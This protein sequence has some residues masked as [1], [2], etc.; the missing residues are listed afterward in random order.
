ML[1]TPLS[2]AQFKGEVLG[3]RKQLA[4][5]QQPVVLARVHRRVLA[6]KREERLSGLLLR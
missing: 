3:Q 4:R 2:P 1:Q 6:L 5:G